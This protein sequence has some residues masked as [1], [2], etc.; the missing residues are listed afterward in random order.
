[1]ARHFV[2]DSALLSGSPIFGRHERRI[3]LGDI[4]RRIVFGGTQA[5]NLDARDATAIHFNNGKTIRAEFK[6]LAAARNEAELI[7]D[8]SANGGVSGI[9]REGNVVLR[10][11]VADIQCSIEDDCA[12]G[13]GEWAF[14]NVEFIVD[15]ADELLEEIFHGD[16]AEDAAELVDDNG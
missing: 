4:G 3:G 8:E 1:M 9:F 15:F 5:L 10:V 2:A 13:Q 16:E 12:V 14:D 7:E 6:T 11:E